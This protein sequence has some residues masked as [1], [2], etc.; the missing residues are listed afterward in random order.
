MASIQKRRNSDGSISYT[1]WVRV[2]PF[3]PVSKTLPSKKDVQAWSD[4]LERELKSKR[5][6]VRTD[7]TTLTV[8]QLTHEFLEDPETKALRTFDSLAPL[9]AWWTNQYGGTKALEF[10][11]A[12]NLRAARDKLR[13]GRAN[14]TV[15]RYLSAMRS[16]WNWARSAGLV[17]IDRV[18]P[19]RLFLTEPKGRTRFLSDD[20]LA[21]LLKAAAA[22]SALINAAIIVSLA[23]GVR[24]SELLRLRWADV[25]LEKQRLRVLLTK[26]D[27]AR[28]VYLP[29][30]AVRSLKVL[31]QSPVL[32]PTVFTSVEG[33]HFSKAQLE[34]RWRLVRK[35]AGLYNF[36]WHDLRHSCASFLA[37]E[38]ANLLEIGAVL[39]HKSTSMTKRYS[40][41]I[42]GAPV[43][44]HTKLDKK[45]SGT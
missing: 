24:Q 39:G 43:T 25:D 31:K 8:A 20:E 21:R 12:L 3:K 4:E 7:L 29:T 11:N 22:H 30:S 44:G 5:K 13:T 40:H 32:G 42:E 10:M 15:N 33:Q 34:C 17:P 9:I 28:G 35:A 41:L 6:A 18:W 38:G 26:N 45:L 37:Q 23:C 19:P 14:A 27:E 36:R 16:C 2:K 1:A